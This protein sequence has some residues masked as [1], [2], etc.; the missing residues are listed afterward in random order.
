MS[1]L[2][3]VLKERKSQENRV[4]MVPSGVKTLTDLGAE[5]WVE[6]QAGVGSGIR[7]QEYEQA[8]AQLTAEREAI[9]A[10]ADLIIKVKEP[11]KDELP[12]YR[13]GQTLYTYL[14]LAADKELTVELA[15]QGVTAI[16]YETIQLEDGSLPL[17]QPMSEVAGRMAVQ[18]AATHLQHNQGGK[19]LLLGGVPGVRR[20]RV[21]I[22]G[23]GIVGMN[24]AKI[25]IG[26]GAEVTILDINPA[27]LA[28][29]DDIYGNRITTL[30]SNPGYVERAVTRADLVVGAVLIPGAKSPKLVSRQMLQAIEDGSVLIDV[31]VDQGGC[32]ATTK[33]TT[34]DN[35]IY[36]VDGVIHY[37]VANIPGTVSRTSTLALTNVTMPYAVQMATQGITNAIK[38]NSAL[39]LG[40][41]TYQGAYTCKAVADAHHLDYKPISSLI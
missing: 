8:G 20:G 29:L 3:G 11:L 36:T 1:M 9:Y 14:H 40:V 5:V 41:N 6:S 39:Q 4:G 10:K 18:L 16:A 13:S 30:V 24:A 35:P 15:K 31:S 17:L 12:L 37:C 22:L 26:L 21:T 33:P 27:K 32:F 38:A 28:Y 2:I 23:A 25:A 34:Y 19:G 7:D